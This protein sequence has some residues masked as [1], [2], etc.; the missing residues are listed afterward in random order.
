MNRGNGGNGG[1]LRR[2]RGGLW[3]AAL[4][5]SGQGC[6]TDVTR[7]EAHRLVSAGALLLDVRSRGEY[8]ERHI[9]GSIN[10]PVEELK[11]R[12]GELGDPARKL[13]VFCHTGIRSGVAV[14]M[15]RKAGFSSVYNLGSIGHWYRE[16]GDPSIGAGGA[17]SR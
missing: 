1:F 7:G 5:V 3:V 11:Q 10:I 14:Q 12:K 15:L 8:A 6:A 2:L 17:G 13:V 4:V 9:D 16:P